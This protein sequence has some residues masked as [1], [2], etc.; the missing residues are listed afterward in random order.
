MIKRFV[1]LMLAVVFLAIAVV[2]TVARADDE[3]EWREHR[4]HYGWNWNRG[5]WDRGHWG[6]HHGERFPDADYWTTHP[7]HYRH[8]LR[9][10][11]LYG[12][13]PYR[14]RYYGEVNPYRYRYY[15]PYAT[16]YSYYY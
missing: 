15:N 6:W 4:P 7:R 5:N 2:P 8:Y 12:N 14:Y 3:D 13:H 11:G 10:H 9:R 1:A 16:P